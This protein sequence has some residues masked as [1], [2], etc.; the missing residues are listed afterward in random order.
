MF[1]RFTLFFSFVAD[2]QHHTES[3]INQF[4]M[5]L[6]DSCIRPLECQAE[7]RQSWLASPGVG[8][9]ER[10][11]WTDPRAALLL[12]FF[13]MTSL[14]LMFSLINP[15]FPVQDIVDTRLSECLRQSVSSSILVRL[16]RTQSLTYQRC[17]QT[18]S[19]ASWLILHMWFVNFSFS[20]PPNL[21]RCVK[22][23]ARIVKC[24]TGRVLK[25]TVCL[26]NIILFECWPRKT[27]DQHDSAGRIS[28]ES[29]G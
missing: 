28:R 6:H 25:T 1:P 22:W 5:C 17:R 12:F 10:I 4:F 7:S 13:N 19:G 29:R 16:K 20:A 18:L 3:G 15:S 21:E 24:V 8:V 14:W 9:A 23:N 2:S 26:Y 27:L 11:T